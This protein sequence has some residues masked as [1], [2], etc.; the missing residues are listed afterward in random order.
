M[1]GMHGKLKIKK[2]DEAG[3]EKK[4]KLYRNKFSSNDPYNFH[5]CV[6]LLMQFISHSMQES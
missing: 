1:L 5:H 3:D 2:V 6:E 4:S